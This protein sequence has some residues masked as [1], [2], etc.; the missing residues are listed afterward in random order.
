MTILHLS[1]PET[2]R[3]FVEAQAV[4]RGLETADEYVRE[5][6]QRELAHEQLRAMILEGANSGPGRPADDAYFAE[7]YARARGEVV[8]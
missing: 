5:L 1:L 8:E 2:L 3:A 7:L 6:I 4:D